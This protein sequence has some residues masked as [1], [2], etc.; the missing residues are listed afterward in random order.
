MSASNNF[1][2]K[3]KHKNVKVPRVFTWCVWF[4]YSMYRNPDRAPVLREWEPPSLKV[5]LLNFNT[6]VTRKP[7]F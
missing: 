5:S 3:Q 1:L 7:G 2:Q 6:H 4:V